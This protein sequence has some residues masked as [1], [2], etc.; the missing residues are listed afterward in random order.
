MKSALFCGFGFAARKLWLPGLLAVG[1]GR[2]GV[3][4]QHAPTAL[5]AVGDWRI[6]PRDELTRLG[7]T[8][9]DVAIV[10]TPTVSHA[11]VAI[12]LLRNGIRTVIEKPVCSSR[13]EL[14]ALRE[15]A[16]QGDAQLLR[17]CSVQYDPHFRQFV[18]RVRE[19]T[20][21]VPATVSAAWL[22]RNGIPN[23][24]WLTRAEHAVAGSCL[25]LG[26]HLLEGVMA[27]TGFTALEAVSA[28]FTAPADGVCPAADAATW[29]GVDRL[30]PAAIDVDTA[31]SIQ[32]RSSAG[33]HVTVDTAWSSMSDGD[34][35]TFTVAQGDVACALRS[36]FGMST[37][38]RPPFGIDLTTRG[39]TR[40]I[41]L[42]FKKPGAAHRAMVA[43]FAEAEFDPAPLGQSWSQL[44]AL[45]GT[46]EAIAD[47]HAAHRG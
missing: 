4:D 36:I 28:T 3:F 41:D 45:V 18:E 27:L 20:A 30:P 46:A 13:A 40:T 23:S 29:Y 22:R 26:W 39:H 14:L 25:D 34:S 5:P 42:P 38:A 17:S 47:L 15:A 31:A 37:D 43:A 19:Y 11:S 10:A 21:D 1:F 24:P 8:D 9:Y 7:A 6:H 35:V 44:D 32:G 33:T 16:G 12:P 2:F